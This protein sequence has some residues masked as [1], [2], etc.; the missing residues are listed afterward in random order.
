MWIYQWR[1]PAGSDVCSGEWSFSRTEPGPWK[2]AD[3]SKAFPS[4]HASLRSPQRTYHH[5]LHTSQRIWAE[6][7]VTGMHSGASPP[8]EASCH[9]NP[10]CIISSRIKTRGM[11]SALTHFLKSQWQRSVSGGC[12]R[13]RL[14]CRGAF[15]VEL[16]SWLENALLNLALL[17]T[18]ALSE[19]EL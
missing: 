1:P 14:N 12:L 17:G 16:P 15:S 6:T 3:S 8:G 11:G 7:K 9:E 5:S 4:V 13:R 2:D 18:L 10:H 19:K